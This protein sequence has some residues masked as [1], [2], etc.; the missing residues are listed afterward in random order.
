MCELFGLSCENEGRADAML[1]KF[2]W[3]SARNPHGWGIACYDHGELTLHK[4]P[5]AALASGDYFRAAEGAGGRV[6]L[7]HV[8]NAS[9][10]EQEER[11]CHPFTWPMGG[12]QWAFAHNGHVDGI[13]PHVRA[14]GETDSESVFHM[15]LDSIR[16]RKDPY[17]GIVEGVRELFEEYEFGREVHLNFVMSDGE[18]VYAFSHH[19]EK[20][21][22]QAL[23]PT[24]R[25]ASVAVATQVLD[26]EPWTPLPADR[27]VVLRNGALDNISEP[28]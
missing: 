19:P 12:R 16:A 9:R 27:L 28:I 4:K 25:G 22:Y 11:N 13:G 26:D 3:H 23:R 14:A 10:G 1:R 2:A 15:L 20:P 18:A 5:E 24:A 7:A 6:I 21:M 17:A 8:R